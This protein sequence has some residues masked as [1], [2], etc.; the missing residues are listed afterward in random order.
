MLD[1]HPDE[2]A[3]QLTLMDHHLLYLI[4][5]SE[6][7]MGNY[8]KEDKSPHLHKVMTRFNL[9]VRWIGSLICA[10]ASEKERRYSIHLLL[11]FVTQFL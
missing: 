3:R 10:N 1:V 9:I 2:F 4:P 6:L 8:A 11:L 7:Q 5:S